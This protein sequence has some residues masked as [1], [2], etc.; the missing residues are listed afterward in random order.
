MTHDIEKLSTQQINSLIA[1]RTDTA[2]ELSGE[3][4]EILN[5]IENL[6][7]EIKRRGDE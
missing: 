1:L 5:E 4:H 7:D 2:L 6:K 3:L